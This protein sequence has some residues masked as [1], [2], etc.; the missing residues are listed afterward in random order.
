[1]ENGISKEGYFGV[2]NFNI[3]E[4]FFQK[5]HFPETFGSSPCIFT[6]KGLIV[7]ICSDC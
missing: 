3:H 5:A 2:E 7:T 4:F 6:K 1:M